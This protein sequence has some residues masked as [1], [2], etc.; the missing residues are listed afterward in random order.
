MIITNQ[1]DTEMRT[2]YIFG[3]CVYIKEPIKITYLLCDNKSYGIAC[4]DK[5]L[6]CVFVTVFFFSFEIELQPDID[7]FVFKYGTLVIPKMQYD[8]NKCIRIQL[9]KKDKSRFSLH[10][11]IELIII[12]TNICV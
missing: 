7:Q 6:H 9:K 4:V 10:L 3:K 2:M 8:T 12:D 5:I 11:L 1:T